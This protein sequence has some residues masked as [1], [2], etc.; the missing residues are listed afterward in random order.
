LGQNGFKK[1]KKEYS[2]DIYYKKLV[3]VY[4]QVLHQNKK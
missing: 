4:N 3:Q 2:P 1:L